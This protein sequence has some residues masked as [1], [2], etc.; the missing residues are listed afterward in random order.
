MSDFPR[1]DL[2]RMVAMSTSS[3]EVRAEGDGNELVGYGAVFNED[4]EISGWEGNFI[5]RIAPGAFRKTLEERADRVKIQFDHG[6]DTRFGGAPIA[7]PVEI[8]ED[9]RGLYV[10]ARFVDT[11][12]GRDARELIRS[13]AVDGMSFRFSVVREDVDK[14]A[15]RLPLRTVRE[16]RLYEVG[17]VT[18]PAY[19]ATTVGVRSAEAMRL[20]RAAQLAT[21]STDG[22]ADSGTPDVTPDTPPVVAPVGAHRKRAEQARRR[23]ALRFPEI[24]EIA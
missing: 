10:R 21:P 20:L 1:D 19:E 16:V 14:N 4:T 24:K 5:E 22:A 12:A 3:L 8:R 17:P 13:G 15:G 7:V 2:I 11:E 18:W 23:L 9:D 6:M